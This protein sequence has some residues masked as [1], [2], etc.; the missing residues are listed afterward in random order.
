MFPRLSMLRSFGYLARRSVATTASRQ[1]SEGTGVSRDAKEFV[2]ML[3]T[4]RLLVPLL[5][6]FGSVFGFVH[7][8]VRRD[9]MYGAILTWYGDSGCISGQPCTL[10]IVIGR[11]WNTTVPQLF[12]VARNR[13][14]KVLC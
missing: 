8:N 1:L 11:Q 10:M 7:Y 14:M 13:I 6:A 4:D 9:C 3:S 2:R 12:N 5:L